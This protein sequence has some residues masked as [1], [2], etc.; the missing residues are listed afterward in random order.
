[1]KVQPKK[2][3]AT[4]ELNANSERMRE[5]F[6]HTSNSYLDNY[7][8]HKKNDQEQRKAANPK[9][10]QSAEDTGKQPRKG[11]R[12]LQTAVVFMQQ[13]KGDTPQE[14]EPIVSPR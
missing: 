8:K 2:L 5:Q 11:K 13:T 1:V 3:G 14:E 9:N 4:K 7:R 12:Q 6:N 10:Q